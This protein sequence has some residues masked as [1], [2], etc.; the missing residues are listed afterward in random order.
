[1]TWRPSKSVTVLR[2][3][4]GSAAVDGSAH[5]NK[6]ASSSPAKAWLR[7]TMVTM[8]KAFAV[9]GPGGGAACRAGPK[10]SEIDRGRQ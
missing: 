7:R 8:V 1:M 3:A 5:P 4:C 6:P 10:V 2:G 9:V